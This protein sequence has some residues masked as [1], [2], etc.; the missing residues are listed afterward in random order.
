MLQ[1]RRNVFHALEGH[2]A[3]VDF[4]DGSGFQRVDELAEE[5]AV[6]QDLEEVVHVAAG[7]DRLASD[8]LD[9]FEALGSQFVAV[10]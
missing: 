2:C 10:F 9:P 5:N 4:L 6:L 3:L 8:F 1:E 7:V